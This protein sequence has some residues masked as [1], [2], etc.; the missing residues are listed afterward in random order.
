MQ[1]GQKSLDE[2]LLKIL[3]T[4]ECLTFASFMDEVETN[5]HFLLS[6]EGA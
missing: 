4:L 1:I 6:E 5:L 2:C 3:G